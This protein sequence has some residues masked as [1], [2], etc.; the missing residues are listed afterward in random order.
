[1]RKAS[2]WYLAVLFMGTASVQASVQPNV[3]L[4]VCDDM[5]D[6]ATTLGGHPQAKTPHID[7]L[8]STGVSFRRAYSNNP[9]CAPS[10]SSFFT[11]IYPHHSGNFS[12]D[13]WFENPVLKNSK[14]MMEY[15]RENGYHVV[16]SGKLM[17]HHQGK[18]WSEF[19][20]K[21]D[22]GPF[23]FDGKDRVAHPAV[24]EP[25]SEIGP[26]DGSFAPL[27]D[28]PFAED[29]DPRTG[30]I[31]GTWG[32]TDPMRYDGPNDRDPT[33]DER[34]ARWAANRLRAFAQDGSSKPFFLAVGFIRPHTPLHVPKKY[35]DL[36][37]LDHLALPVILPDDADDT[38]FAEVLDPSQK[39]LRYFRL[40]GESYPDADRGLK[41][42]TQAYLAS[43]AAVDDCIG[44]VVEAVD[45]S[46]LRKNTI[47][48][49]TSDHGWQMGQK[50]YLFK[51]SPWEESTRIPLIIRAPGVTRSGGVA[52]HPV[53]LID[54][55]PTLIDLCGLSGETRKSEQGAPLDGHSM[56][57]FLEDPKSCQ[58]D[59]PG[60]ALSMIYLGKS[61]KKYT[62]RQRQQ[63]ENQHWSYRTHSWRYILYNN[64]EEELYH[65]QD[66]P[67]EWHNLADSPECETIKNSLR[68]KMFELRNQSHT[69]KP[70]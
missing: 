23:V 66:D 48:V 2:L 67:H 24:P 42:F 39:G 36:F 9:I 61:R 30:W 56:R 11:G 7:E 4:I 15:F 57:P 50:D 5:N 55:Y 13:K 29:D 52:E 70:D 68:R 53:S 38:S 46:S 22:Y 20:H 26:V 47:V 58:W 54:L 8:A 31:Y 25:F 63:P 32:K 10:R 49:L 44:E 40:I 27:D 34:N 64:G 6:Y 12:F 62:A 18:I 43:V 45:R 41:V 28:V 35:F 14:T 16:G 3:V 19:E 17:H 1:M 37:P 59:G 51:N 60:G 69:M 65:H 33:P 21:A